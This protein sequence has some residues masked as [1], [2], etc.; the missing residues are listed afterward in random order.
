MGW[1]EYY[2]RQDALDRVLESPAGELVWDDAEFGSRREVLL[3]LQHRWAQ[4]LRGRLAVTEVDA[5]PAVD[6]TDAV[7]AAWRALAA[8]EPRLR[9]LLDRYA[10][11][12]GG[13]TRIEHR[14]VAVAAGLA[15]ATE[16]AADAARIGTAFLALIRPHPTPALTG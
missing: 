14:D 16:P 7:A 4:R 10:P 6:R 13:S 8:E 5:D 9:A 15:D 2:R 3:A 12:L 1:S 11:E